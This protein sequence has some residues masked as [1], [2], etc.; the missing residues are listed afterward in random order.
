MDLLE[1]DLRDLGRVRAQ[2]GF[3]DRVLVVAG[4]VPGGVD[5]YAELETP[6]GVLDVAWNTDGISAVRLARVGDD[7]ERWFGNRLSRRAVRVARPP[8]RLVGQIVDAIAGRSPRLRF[9]LGRLS[10]FEQEVLRK[11]LEI[12]RGEV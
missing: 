3:A 8:D 11:T 9:D 10:A 2:D 1:K 6:L 12:P 7:F 4:I 5:A